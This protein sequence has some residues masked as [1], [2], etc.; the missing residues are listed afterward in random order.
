MPAIVQ[1]DNNDNL[2]QHPTIKKSS[3]SLIAVGDLHGNALK[4]LH[5]LLK[6][7][8][9]FWP[10]DDA[11][12]P[13]ERYQEFYHAYYASPVTVA[14]LATIKGLIKK[15]RAPPNC[16]YLR[17]LGDELADRGQNDLI[18]LWL[19]ECLDEH[20]LAY[21]CCFSNHTHIFMSL[22]QQ[23]IINQ[24][25]LPALNLAFQSINSLYWCMTN[26][27]IEQEEIIRL[28]NN[29]KKHLRII[30]YGLDD[31]GIY[32]YSHAPTSHNIDKHLAKKLGLFYI[33]NTPEFR[34]WSIEAINQKFTSLLD[35][36]Q[37][38]SLFDQNTI[39]S[40]SNKVTLSEEEHPFEHTIWN[41]RYDALS[42]PLKHPQ[43]QYSQ[44]SAHGHDSEEPNDDQEYIICLDALFGKGEFYQECSE[45]IQN[46]ILHRNEWRL[47]SEKMLDIEVKIKEF[48]KTELAQLLKQTTHQQINHLQHLMTKVAYYQQLLGDER[49]SELHPAILSLINYAYEQKSISLSAIQNDQRKTQQLS[50]SIHEL[51]E[52]IAQL[53]QYNCIVDVLEHYERSWQDKLV[54]HQTLEELAQQ[55]LAL[56]IACQKKIKQ[57]QL[58]YAHL[59]PLIRDCI[60]LFKTEG[61]SLLSEG[62][63]F[64]S[65][66]QR[67]LKQ[68]IEQEYQAI[69]ELNFYNET[70]LLAHRLK[71]LITLAEELEVP[72]EEKY[73]RLLY[74]II[75]N[76][77]KIAREYLEQCSKYELYNEELNKLAKTQT[78]TNT[79]H[80]FIRVKSLV[81]VTLG[82]LNTPSAQLNNQLENLKYI[83]ASQIERLYTQEQRS[84]EEQLKQELTSEKL[85]NL[86]HRILILKAVVSPQKTFIDLEQQLAE[87]WRQLDKLREL[88]KELFVRCCV[89]NKRLLLALSQ[90]PQD[91]QIQEKIDIMRRLIAS[92]QTVPLIS[93]ALSAFSNEFINKHQ[94]LQARRKL[95][96]ITLSTHGAI[97]RALSFF[98]RKTSLKF[99]HGADFVQEITNL[100]YSNGYD[101]DLKQV[102]ILSPVK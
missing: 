85:L 30:N 27:L 92:L 70:H 12:P 37:M 83:Y 102:P 14:N 45:L 79:N 20:G 13:E 59:S 43:H 8:V 51:R 11:T 21:D 49:F 41:R 76:E 25:P 98:S 91:T 29:H 34:A 61:C 9:L 77:E 23:V 84:I 96:D 31:S 74:E 33:D 10:T 50:E 65:K 38:P 57:E 99:S 19:F 24:E 87:N 28:V 89:Y 81:E 60:D 80:F 40:L 78:E 69:Y 1:K 26:G 54:E 88:K 58:N 32:Q 47:S 95:A 44:G 39:I 100:L 52:R 62:S 16:P 66:L 71:N 94:T 63:D 90:N 6:T 46:P 68:S 75:L 17:F 4:L 18:S 22:Y 53:K 3:L 93:Q 7:G 56:F 55:K 5:F 73:Q 36:G 72:L 86:K 15:L 97:N 82:Y 48:I 2:K 101:I 67:A 64:Q 42:R 35:S